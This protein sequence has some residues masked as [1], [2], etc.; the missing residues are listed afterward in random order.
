MLIPKHHRQRLTEIGHGY[1]FWY[2]IS[3]WAFGERYKFKNGVIAY[4][5]A[6]EIVSL[7]KGAKVIW[8]LEVK[9]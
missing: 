2:Q 1:W 3:D 6:G 4:L 7:R 9:L 5:Y 8:K